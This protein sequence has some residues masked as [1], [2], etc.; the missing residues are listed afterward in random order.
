[1][2]SYKPLFRYLLEQDIS[3][4]ECRQMCGISPNTWTK[5]NKNEEVSLTILNKLCAGLGVSYN[6]IIEYVPIEEQNTEI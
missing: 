3:K 6:D 2:V 1:M 4:S 5:I